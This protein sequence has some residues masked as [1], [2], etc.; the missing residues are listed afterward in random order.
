MR[1]L[2]I[3]YG[4]IAGV[5]VAVSSNIVA[6]LSSRLG[7]IQSV[8]LGYL[9]MLAALSLVFVGVRRYR[10]EYLGGIIRFGTALGVGA[11]ISAV[12]CVFYVLGWE[13]NLLLSGYTFAP[14]YAAGVVDA[15][16]AAGSSPE[17]I[18]QVREEMRQFVASYGNPVYRSILTLREIG[19]VA[20]LV[21]LLS[22]ALLRNSRFMPTHAD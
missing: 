17:R 11:A 19:P 21:S 22:A 5:I 12:A 3:V 8:S 2:V 7:A 20:A 6:A 15:E 18:A 1:R 16:I 9:V 13:I 4:C 14:D 10:D